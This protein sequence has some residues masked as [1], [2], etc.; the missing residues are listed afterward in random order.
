M[1]VKNDFTTHTHRHVM[2]IAY[3]RTRPMV[4]RILPYWAIKVKNQREKKSFVKNPTNNT[5]TE[6]WQ[7]ANMTIIVP[8]VAFTV[9]I[10]DKCFDHHI[11]DI[12]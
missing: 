8:F 12:L 5:F 1:P 2:V 11:A 7:Y 3:S 9:L 10:C 4:K 6:H